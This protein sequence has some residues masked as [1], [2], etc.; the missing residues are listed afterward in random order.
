MQP[1][2]R[3]DTD[4]LVKSSMQSLKHLSTKREYIYGVSSV[5][6]LWLV[7]LEWLTLIKSFIWRFSIRFCSSC[8]SAALRLGLV[9]AWMISIEACYLLT[10]PLCSREVRR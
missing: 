10:L 3:D 5:Y 2:S 6:H 7:Y 1:S 4:L 8:C 9:L